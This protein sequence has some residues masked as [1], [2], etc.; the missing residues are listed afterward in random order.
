MLTTNIS[1][2]DLN[3]FLC[4]F[5]ASSKGAANEYR[6]NCFFSSDG[7]PASARI[8]Q[9]CRALSRRLQS[10][11][12]F[13]HGPILMHGLRAINLSRKSARY[14][15]L[16]T[17]HADKTLSHGY[18]WSS[19]TQHSCECE[20]S[21]GLAYLC[22]LCA[23]INSYCQRFVSQRTTGHRTRRDG[24]RAGCDSYR[25]MPISIPMGIFS[26]EQRCNQTSY[27]S[28]SARQH[29]IIYRDHRRESLR[30]QYSGYDYSR[31]RFILHNGS[32]LSRLQKTLCFASNTS[33]LCNQ[34]KAQSSVPSDLFTADQKINRLTLRS[35]DSLN[36][37]EIIPTL[38]RSNSFDKILRCRA[39][40]T[41]HILDQQ[42]SSSRC[43]SHCSTVQIPLE[44]R[45]IFQMDQTTLAY[46]SIFGNIPEC[47]QDTNLDCHLGLRADCNYQK[48]F[49]HQG[50]TLHN[51]TNLKRDRF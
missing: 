47:R 6:Q 40:Q 24:L 23:S 15:S 44:S 21:T 38:S 9:M 45:T 5:G 1:V 26:K 49:G 11:K 32:R 35:N 28:G 18:S 48:T 12:F 37:A 30:S 20:Q 22:R 27:A 17:I 46:Q 43:V 50:R 36:R 34:S 16:P 19:V 39:R 31:S 41:L 14:P 2:I 29:P 42:F 8:P 7:I 10:Q 13:M 25:F 4:Y 33:I 3:S 51:F